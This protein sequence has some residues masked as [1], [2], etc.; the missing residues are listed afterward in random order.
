MLMF[1]SYLLQFGCCGFSPTP[2]PCVTDQQFVDELLLLRRAPEL[3]KGCAWSRVPVAG[4][5]VWWG[6]DT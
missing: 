5:L 4:E 1:G 2:W 6:P 3:R